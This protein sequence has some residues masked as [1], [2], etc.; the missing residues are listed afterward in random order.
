[1]SQ[2]LRR[3]RIES[4]DNIVILYKHQNDDQYLPAKLY[5]FSKRG[6]KIL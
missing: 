5:N 4:G 2:T 1:M 3:N 6:M